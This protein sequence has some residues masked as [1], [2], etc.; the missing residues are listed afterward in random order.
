VNLGNDVLNCGECGT[1]CEG[2]HPYCAG[3]ECQPT[4]PCGDGPS[5]DGAGEFCCGATCCAAGEICCSIPGPID[6]ATVCTVPDER[7]TCPLGCLQ[8]DCNAPDT[9]IATPEG[10]RTI[11]SLSPGD[12]V[13]SIDGD[14]IVAVP[15]A[16]AVQNP[17]SDHRVVRLW[18]EDGSTLQI[19]ARHPLADGRAIGELRAFD[20][21]GDAVIARAELAQYA[22]P[23]THDILP[24][25]STGIYFVAGMALR[26]TLH[27]SGGADRP[28]GL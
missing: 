10:D 1:R 4:P 21:Y 26:S 19:S 8:C 6:R 2:D 28:L 13:Y 16:H 24:A 7:G 22:L 9:P 14:A 11:A 5:C 15:I 17:V 20:H 25:S 3:G 18:L 23:F 27:P 12:L